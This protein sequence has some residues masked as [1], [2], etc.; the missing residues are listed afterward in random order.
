MQVTV[1]FLGCDHQVVTST[2]Q[3]LHKGLLAANMVA[4][5]VDGRIKRHAGLCAEC[6]K[7]VARAANEPAVRHMWRLGDHPAKYGA[8]F[9]GRVKHYNRAKGCGF[10]D[11]LGVDGR[12]TGKQLF[13]YGGDVWHAFAYERHPAIKL[14]RHGH[15]WIEPMPMMGDLVAYCI[16]NGRPNDKAVGI[17]HAAEFQLVYQQLKGMLVGG[18][19]CALTSH[20]LTGAW[21]VQDLIHNHW[22]EIMDLQ[23]TATQRAA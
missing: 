9:L 7:N 13:F 10:I 8:I 20:V 5:I 4:S 19:I 2:E 22:I 11:D 18:D 14:E 1:E 6:R 3:A 16:S 15:G 21:G 17:C 23:P 12:A